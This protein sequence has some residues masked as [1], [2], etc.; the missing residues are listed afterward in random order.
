MAHRGDSKNIPE[1]TLQAFKDA[2][3]LGVDCIETDVR[4]TKD[5]QFVFLHDKNLN[6]TTDHNGLVSQYTLSD[7]KKFDAG[8]RYKSD[9][10]NSENKFPFRG[11]GFQLQTLD[12]IIPQFPKVR[13]N[14]DIKDKDPKAPELLAQKLVNL[15]VEDRV[16]V[17][18]FHDDQI[19]RFRM[20]SKVPTGAAPQEVWKYRKIAIKWL[21]T[22]RNIPE[23]DPSQFESLQKQIFGNLLPFKA[24]QIPEKLVL[25]IITPLFIGFSHM[26]GIA[27]QVWTINDEKTMR[28]LITWNVDGIFTDNP[29][30]LLKVLKDF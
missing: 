16:F 5:A 19:K 22:N 4:M 15:K 6:R 11:K 20:L 14:M 3:S 25:R 21:K 8:F 10:K 13:F 24:L 18:S 26:L 7:L 28:K 12:E 29:G 27:I 9:N 1:N 2:Y 23:P 30:L 17:S